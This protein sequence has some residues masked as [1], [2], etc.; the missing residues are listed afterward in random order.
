MIVGIVLKKTNWS[1]IPH[2]WRLKFILSCQWLRM[3]LDLY[4]WVFPKK[5]S[6]WGSFA[7]TSS[8]LKGWLFQHWYSPSW[9]V[10][11][12]EL[13]HQHQP[14]GPYCTR[15]SPEN[16]T[17]EMVWILIGP[18]KHACNIMFSLARLHICVIQLFQKTY[19]SFIRNSGYCAKS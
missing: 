16:T 15:T 13:Y 17:H 9:Y 18:T 12:F 10:R 4:S 7:T 2:L 8:Y 11:C 5:V 19:F 6:S 1:S 14:Q 3:L